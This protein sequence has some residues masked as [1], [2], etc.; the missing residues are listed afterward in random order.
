MLQEQENIGLPQA[1]SEFG[2]ARDQGFVR[3]Q[4]IQRRQRLADTS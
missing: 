3:E 2:L 1:P 4:N